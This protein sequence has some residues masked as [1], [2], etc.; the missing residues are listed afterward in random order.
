[1]CSL[2]QFWLENPCALTQS[3]DI[4]PD[5]HDSLEEQLNAAS[6]CIILLWVLLWSL[7][8]KYHLYFLLFSLLFII[9]LYYIQINSMRESFETLPIQQWKYLPNPTNLHIENPTQFRFCQDSRAIPANQSYYS[10]NQALAAPPNKVA[11]NP[12]TRRPPLV[13][14]PTHAFD[15]WSEDFMVPSGINDETNNELYLSGHV[16]TSKCTQNYDMELEQFPSDYQKK[17]YPPSPACGPACGTE[18]S[19]PVP[20]TRKDVIEPFAYKGH[21]PNN[22]HE[23]VKPGDI[24]G[25]SYNPS[26]LK[27]NIPTNAVVGQ[28][29]LNDCYNDYNKNMYTNYIGPDTYVQNQV[30]DSYQSNI[31]V[32]YAQQFHPVRCEMENGK[33]V[34]V[35][36][37]SRLATPAQPIQRPPEVTNANVYDPRSNGYG[38]SYRQYIDPMTGQPRF[39][40]DDID[41]VRRPNFII[42]S[43]VD[44]ASWAPTYGTMTKDTNVANE[45]SHGLANRQFLEGAL[46]QREELQE[47]YMRSYNAK[48]GY[49][50]R[51]APIHTNSTL[52]GG[53]G[54]NRNNG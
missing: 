54:V 2:Q 42:R 19:V 32:D 41:A 4:V 22:S 35:E 12:K 17:V 25:C 15:Y 8:Y 51:Q 39:Y 38:T 5:K 3:T 6:R 53:L 26:H 29:S 18:P 30:T 11:G 37:D 33:R 9:I 14:S 21:I 34:Y 52:L 46:T 28:C 16:G 13:I 44:H 7:K 47:R 20:D 48:R 49:Q 23:A 1:M 24:R 36:E 43:N 40:Y 45:L 27:H 31:G 10:T 50:L